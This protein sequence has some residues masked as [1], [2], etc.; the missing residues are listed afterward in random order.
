MIAGLAKRS[1]FMVDI[2]QPAEPGKLTLR[3][4]NSIIPE[5]MRQDFTDYWTYKLGASLQKNGHLDRYYQA[6]TRPV[7]ICTKLERG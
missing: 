3:N 7:S 5:S 6:L 4:E 2:K 1:A